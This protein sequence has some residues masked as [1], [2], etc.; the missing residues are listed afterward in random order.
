MWQERALCTIQ[1]DL[2]T[3][4]TLIR[5][6]YEPDSVRIVQLSDADRIYARFPL[7]PC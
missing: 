6:R 2:R 4:Q 3:L 7:L 5:A 1:H